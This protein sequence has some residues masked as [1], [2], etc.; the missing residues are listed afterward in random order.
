MNQSRK[1]LIPTQA[2]GLFLLACLAVPAFGRGG[3]EYQKGNEVIVDIYGDGRQV[4]NGVVEEIYRYSSGTFYSVIWDCGD[5]Y[6]RSN[7]GVVPASRLRPRG[8]TKTPAL[9]DNAN[10]VSS[11][12]ARRQPAAARD[13]DDSDVTTEVSAADLDFFVGKWK[14]SRYGGGSNVERDGKIYRETLLYVAKAAP[15]VINADGTYSWTVRDGSVVRGKWRKLRPE[16]DNLTNGKNGLVLLRGFDDVDWRVYLTSVETGKEA[17]KIHSH[18]GNFDG[19][20]IGASKGEPAWNKVQFAAGEQVIVTAPDG[21]QCNAVIDK[22]AR[23]YTG[24]VTYYVYFTCPGASR[25]S[26]SFPAHKIR[27]P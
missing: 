8:N 9:K 27:R 16:E 6:S 7:T 26:G 12:D 19:E 4:C 24:L 10:P 5:G 22:P 25:T 13:N 2:F 18:L 20:R 15:I 3:D 1:S 23:D 17:I 11:R 21:T 14:L